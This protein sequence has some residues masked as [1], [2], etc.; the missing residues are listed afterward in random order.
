MK[1]KEK[2]YNFIA[3]SGINIMHRCFP[4]YFATEPLRPTDRYVEYPW[5]LT[6][7][8][9]GSKILDVGCAGSMFPLLINSLY[10][11]VWGIDI[12]P[13]P[14]AGEFYFLR[15]DICNSNHLDTWFD[16]VT[17]ISTIEHIGIGGRY[18]VVPHAEG[19]AKAIKEIYRI[20]KPGGMF[21]MT[22]PFGEEYRITPT[23]RIYNASMMETLLHDF[24]YEYE[25]VPSPEADYELALIKAVK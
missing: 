4:E 6:S 22:V 9:R 17:A 24:D 10:G 2:L 19:D 20:L 7:I 13:H 21:L 1:A 5:A 11:R 12:R 25:T 18:G 8:P 16:V 14:M 23:H 3:H 15:G